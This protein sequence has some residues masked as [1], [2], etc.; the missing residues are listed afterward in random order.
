MEIRGGGGDWVFFF[1]NYAEEKVGEC[2][3]ERGPEE[4]GDGGGCSKG[5]G[6]SIVEE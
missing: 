1:V 5:A 3:T 2:G 6:G 4:G